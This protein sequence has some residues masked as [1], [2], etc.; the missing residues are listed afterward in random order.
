MKKLVTALIV[1]FIIIISLLIQINLLNIIP[2]FGVAANIGIV[3][4]VG[5]SLMSGRFV[6]ALTGGVYGLLVDVIFSKTIG[7][8]ILLY[9]LVGALTGHIS[10]GFSKD[11]KAAMVM[12][13]S[14]TTVLFELASVFALMLL[15][16]GQLDMIR[17]LII[18]ALEVVYNIL[19]TLIFNKFIVAIGEIINKSKNSYYLL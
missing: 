14:I 16:N 7:I 6:G 12:V 5:L 8:N 10:N 2:L 18:I 9:I 15:Q 13:V 4:V 1:F 11:N 19:L 3:L 17:V